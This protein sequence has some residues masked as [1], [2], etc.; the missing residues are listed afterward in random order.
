MV[1]KFYEVM[2]KS[3]VYIYEDDGWKNLLP[4]TNLN[5]VFELVCG[6]WSVIERVKKIY[7]EVTP[8]SRMHRNERGKGLYINGRAILYDRL[9]IE[10]DEE[11]FTSNNEIVSFRSKDGRLPSKAR[12][13]QVEAFL[14]KYPWDLIRINREI[15]RRDFE[16]ANY[17]QRYTKGISIDGDIEL[18]FIDDESKIFKGVYLNTENGPIY[19]DRGAQIRPPTVIYGPS[20]IGQGAIIDGAKIREGCSIGEGCRIGGE[21]E[22]SIF[23][24]YSNKHH[25]GFVGHSYIGRWVNLGALTTT[26]DLKNT[27]EKIE[28]DLP[29]GKINTNLLKFG[30]IIGEHTKTGI[31]T[32]LTT[33]CVIGIFCNLYGG[34]TFGRYIESFSWGTYN[35]LSLHRLDKA[36]E[37]ARKVMKRRGIKPTKQYIERIA[38]IF[39]QISST[40][41]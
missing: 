5:P 11:I 26:S 23:L 31:G 16:H 8:V 39:K 9:A 10:G 24:S 7:S 14:F 15:I 36:L 6:L 38:S 30:S 41:E 35:D 19:I 21:I 40:S 3:K 28:V 27:Y 33:G 37:T 4:L 1:F 22:E 17:N 18:C 34:G 12:I 13:T 2:V 32:L 20:Y 29:S 25:D